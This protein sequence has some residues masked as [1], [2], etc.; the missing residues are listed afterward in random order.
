MKIALYI[1]DGFEQIVLTPEGKFEISVLDMLRSGERTLTIKK[2]EFY[3]TCGGYLRQ[4][5]SMDSTLL[6]LRRVKPDAEE[7]HTNAPL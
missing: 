2:T 4:G 6:V 1:E 3:E 7:D 5:S